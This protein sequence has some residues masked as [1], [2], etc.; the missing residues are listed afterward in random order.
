MMNLEEKLE[1]AVKQFSPVFGPIK[2]QVT[3]VYQEGEGY[4]CDGQPCRPNGEV[5]ADKA[6]IRKIPIDPL[7]NGDERGLYVLPEVGGFIRVGF[8]ENDSNFPYFDNQLGDGFTLTGAKIAEVLLKHSPRSQLHILGDGI[9]QILAPAFYLFCGRKDA[10]QYQIELDPVLKRLRLLDKS[11]NEFVLDGKNG[12]LTWTLSGN[13]EI[14]IDGVSS[15][16]WKGRNWMV[17]GPD[18]LLV[19]GQ[20]QW[21]FLDKL[22]FLVSGNLTIDTALGNIVIKAALGDIE[23]SPTAGKVSITSVQEITVE[24]GANSLTVS[25]S[26]IEATVGGT[27]LSISTTGVEV[28]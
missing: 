14:A 11:G 7:F 6:L 28:T 20:A 22:K 25:T 8:Y 18:E 2:C 1:E 3:R 15:R 23:I 19:T 27:N 10:E 16:S 13:E 4:Y 24:V 17:K 26:G 21:S 9:W 12:S 5:R